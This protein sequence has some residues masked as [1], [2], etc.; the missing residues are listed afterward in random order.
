M[1]IGLQP[2]LRH[3]AKRHQAFLATLAH[4]TEH[5]LVHTHV[6]CLERDQFRHTQAARIHQFQHG[7]I[8]QPQRGGKVRCPQQGLHLGL[9]QGLG[10]AQGLARG[11]HTHGGIGLNLALPQGP[12]EETLENGQAPVGRGGPGLAVAVGK[13]TIEVG[14]VGLQHI[15]AMAT[16][17]RPEQGEIPPI[18][19]QRIARQALLQPQRIYKRLDHSLA[20][21]M[22]RPVERRFKHGRRGHCAGI[23][24]TEKLPMYTVRTRV[25]PSATSDTP[26]GCRM[27]TCVILPF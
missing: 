18:S 20:S 26:R 9:G 14:F 17:P 2:L 12:T 3:L 25:N 10:H 11:L 16:Q 7:T 1:Q 6:P 21:R 15:L 23:K 8:A 19:V 4:D 27:A 5:T 24:S 13:I 22:V